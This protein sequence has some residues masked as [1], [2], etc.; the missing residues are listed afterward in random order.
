MFGFKPN[1]ISACMLFICT[2]LG[3]VSFLPQIIKT[4]KTK[5]AEDI[6]VLSWII[7][8]VGYVIT[9]VYAFVFTEDWVFFVLEIVE[10][11]VCF[12]TLMTCLRF[13]KGRI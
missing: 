8:I 1:Y 10:G 5:K 3:F 13:G 2:V 7:W 9:A 6:S 12:F 11:G 4:F